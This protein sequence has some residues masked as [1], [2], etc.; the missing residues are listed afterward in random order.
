MSVEQLEMIIKEMDGEKVSFEMFKENDKIWSWIDI[1]R[2][3]VSEAA[4]SHWQ[5][6]ITDSGSC[7]RR[8][9]Q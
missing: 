1:T 7:V 5:H 4:A 2:Q 8:G 9:R 3:N 6:T